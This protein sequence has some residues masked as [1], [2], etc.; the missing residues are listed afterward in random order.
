MSENYVPPNVKL[1]SSE[2][3]G[4]DVPEGF[5]HGRKAGIMEKL[6][7]LFSNPD[8]DIWLRGLTP[9]QFPQIKIF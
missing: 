9:L 4:R 2:Y 1:I 8:S 7:I 5:I 3:S 6:N